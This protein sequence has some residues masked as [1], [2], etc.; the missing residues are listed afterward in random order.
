[1]IYKI[2]I[3]KYIIFYAVIVLGIRSFVLYRNTG[4]NPFKKMG[5]DRIQGINEKVLMFGPTLVPV[6]VLF[7]L[8]SENLYNYLNPVKYLEFDALLCSSTAKKI[9]NSS[10][11]CVVS[12]SRN[13]YL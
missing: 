4:I 9:Q 5:E 11:E 6:I 8:L 10:I 2:A 7:Y 12:F 1:M 3:I 13:T